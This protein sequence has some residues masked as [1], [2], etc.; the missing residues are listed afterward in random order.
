M[1]FR[2]RKKLLILSL[3]QLTIIILSFIIYHKVSLLSYIN[4]S[5]YFSAAFLLAALLIYTINGGFYD[6]ISRSF[7]LAFSK[8]D[9]KRKFEEIPGLSELITINEKPLL[10]HGLVT[11]LLMGIA[12]IAYYLLL[13]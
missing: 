10:F 6:V 1:N 12:L 13:T 5:F 8:T 2:A 9:K 7:N 3:T 11:G 4:I